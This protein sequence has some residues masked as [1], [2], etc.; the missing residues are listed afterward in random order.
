MI[1][2]KCYE[3]E[4]VMK[5]LLIKYLRHNC[6]IFE[7]LI[8]CCLTITAF[9]LV[10]SFIV[11][12]AFL[13]KFLIKISNEELRNQK[14]LIKLNLLLMLKLIYFSNPFRMTFILRLNLP[15]SW[16]IRWES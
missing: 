10:D 12:S 14:L 5:V 4:G 1:Y 13:L 15:S 6:Q 11:H 9:T 16:I 2:I 7:F 3:G 8:T